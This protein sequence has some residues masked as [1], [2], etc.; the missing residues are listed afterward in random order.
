MIYLKA[1]HHYSRI[2]FIIPIWRLSIYGSLPPGLRLHPLLSHGGEA[3]TSA[4]GL[5]GR[6]PGGRLRRGPGR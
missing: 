5:R 1:I 3:E 4:P 2:S 6:H